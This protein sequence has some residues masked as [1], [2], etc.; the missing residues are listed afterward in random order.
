MVCYH[1][2]AEIR[3]MAHQ[4]HIMEQA[5]LIRDAVEDDPAFLGEPGPGPTPTQE[6]L[7]DLTRV[8]AFFHKRIRFPA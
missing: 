3:E 4:L 2:P 7:D 8:V 1:T 6:Q 5:Q